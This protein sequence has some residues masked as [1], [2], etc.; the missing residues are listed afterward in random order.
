MATEIERTEVYNIKK[1]LLIAV[2]VGTNFNVTH[3]KQLEN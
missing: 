1:S 2:N 3:S